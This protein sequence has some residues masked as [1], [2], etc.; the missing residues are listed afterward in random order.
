MQALNTFFEK[1]RI[2]YARFFR[3]VLVIQFGMVLFTYLLVFLLNPSPT[4]TLAL[5]RTITIWLFIGIIVG[6]LIGIGIL[7]RPYINK[8]WDIHEIAPSF[9]FRFALI[10]I[11]LTLLGII[12]QPKGFQVPLFNIGFVIGGFFTIAAYETE[13][14]KEHMVRTKDLD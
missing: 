8:V 4:A 13:I 7:I 12:L 3:I 2:E 9:L 5:F 6:I 1:N 10:F 11:I 14:A